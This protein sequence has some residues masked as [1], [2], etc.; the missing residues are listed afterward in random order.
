ML[1]CLPIDWDP[2]AAAG[3]LQEY[4]KVRQ[5]T[6]LELELLNPL[7]YAVWLRTLAWLVVLQLTPS[8]GLSRTA[9]PISRPFSA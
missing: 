5:L 3:L 2:V 9:Y 7:T 6:Q 8:Y 1:E 4:C